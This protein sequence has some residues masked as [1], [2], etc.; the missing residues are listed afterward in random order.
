MRK[1]IYYIA[2]SADGFICRPNGSIEDF[3]FDGEHVL[4]LLEAFPETIPTHLRPQLKIEAENKR[5]DTVL[6]GRRT[7]EVGEAYGITSPY[8]HLEQYLFST[9]LSNS[10]SADVVLVSSDAVQCVRDLKSR[11]GL[12]IWLCGGSELASALIEEID[13]IIIKSN[14]FLMGCG[15]S[16]FAR[17]TPKIELDLIDRRNYACGFTLQHF[18]VCRDSQSG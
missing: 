9:S 15:K 8:E 10:P 16:L 5:F 7:Y 3:T 6:M 14:P 13:E 18:G 2:T 4:D 11:D 1:L 17:E 12:D